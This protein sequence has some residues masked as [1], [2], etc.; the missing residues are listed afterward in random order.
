[1]ST[2]TFKPVNVPIF[3]DNYNICDCGEHVFNKNIKKN[4]KI[5]T[6]CS[7]KGFKET[8]LS[9]TNATVKQ[10][11]KIHVLMALTWID[12]YDPEKHD[13]VHKDE[14]AS[15]NKLSNLEIVEKQDEVEIPCP[16]F[17][18]ISDDYP[19]FNNLYKICKCGKHIV[20]K[21]SNI[22]LNQ[23]KTRG[24]YYEVSL[25]I[26]G[27]DNEKSKRIVVHR[28]MASTFLVKPGPEYTQVDH[29]DRNR[30]N[31]KLENLHY[32]TPSMNQQNSSRKKHAISQFD[33]NGEFVKE[34][35]SLDTLLNNNPEYAK[36]RIY[37]CITAD[38]Y[39]KIE[40]YGYRWKYSSE[41]YIKQIFVPEPNEEVKTLDVLKYYNYN[42]HE[43]QEFDVSAYKFTSFG[44]VIKSKTNKVLQP[45]IYDNSE[46]LKMGLT[47][48]EKSKQVY[49]H[50]LIAN[51]FHPLSELP[52]EK[53]CVKF[54]D[55]N[56]KN[57]HADNLEWIP[58]RARCIEVSGKKLSAKSVENPEKVHMF[59]SISEGIDFLKENFTEA[60]SSASFHRG[61]RACLTGY[62]E[63]AYGYTWTEV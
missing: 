30:D 63:T 31:N 25:R 29:K 22:L 48:G 6:D 14:N 16:L 19:Q 37:K 53:M 41:N 61:I 11:F 56:P 55:N 44:K 18:M 32:V 23:H 20:S 39:M 40:A 33:L 3:C 59:N 50:V 28:L 21:N 34:Y 8:N 1:M 24:G 13:I 46:L 49:L 17:D 52:V 60:S 43:F 36:Y 38:D 35:E 27:E 4:M 57:C 51:V 2:C 15:N 58:Y 45:N 54:K 9:H 47:F 26:P 7:G 62:Q 12:G 42:L 10:K 5:R